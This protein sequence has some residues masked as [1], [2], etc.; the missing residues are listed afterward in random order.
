[1]NPYFSYKN[2]TCTGVWS[3]RI[4]DEMHRVRPQAAFEELSDSFGELGWS[5]D[6]VIFISSDAPRSRVKSQKIASY[7]LI[8]PT[9]VPI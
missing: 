2:D 7:R 3:D 5:R 9:T 6:G 1:L 4:L 8:Q